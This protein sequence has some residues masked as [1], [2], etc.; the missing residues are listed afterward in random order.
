MGKF[1]LTVSAFTTSTTVTT[2]IG[3][4]PNAA[5]ETGECVEVVMTGSGTTTAADTQHRCQVTYC[6]YATTGV[7]ST[8]TPEPFHQGARASQ[9]IAGHTFTTEPSTYSSQPSINFGFN[10]RGGMRWAVPQGEGLVMLGGHDDEGLGVRVISAAAG[11]IDAHAHY[12]E[13]G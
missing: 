13:A 9:F 2:G 3:F 7:S 4:S 6:T 1:A 8:A 12:W 10:Q 11:A 5:G